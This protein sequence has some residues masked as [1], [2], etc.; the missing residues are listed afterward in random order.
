MKQFLKR[1][2]DWL[3]KIS[4][5]SLAVGMFQGGEN[6]TF[7]VAIGVGSLLL[8]FVLDCLGRKL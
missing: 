8:C 2:A 6:A 5:A 7:G 1:F 3:E 4:V